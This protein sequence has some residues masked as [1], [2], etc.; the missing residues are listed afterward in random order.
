MI[1]NSL[2]NIKKEILIIMAVL[3]FGAGLLFYFSDKISRIGEVKLTREEII[4]IQMEELDKLRE[5]AAANPLTEEKKKIQMEE[6]D[7]LRAESRAK[8]LS[9]EE[10]N[11]QIEELNKLR[12]QQ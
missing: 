11:K 10:I 6:L 12:T 8:P 3:A 9:Q 2:G 7:K 4:K 1:N 5:Q